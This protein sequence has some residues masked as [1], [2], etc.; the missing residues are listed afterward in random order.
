M[1]EASVNILLG[2]EAGQGLQTVGP[3]LAKSLVRKGYS[4][5]VTQTYESRVRGGHNVFAIRAGTGKILSPCDNIDIL[6]CLNE[7][8]FQINRDYLTTDALVICVE[9][10]KIDYERQIV[11]PSNLPGEKVTRN[12]AAIGIVAGLIGVDKNSL[13]QVFKDSL[14]NRKANEN[15]DIIEAVYL[16][17]D[18]KKID[19]KP[20]PKII[21]PEKKWLL[22]GHEAV[23]FG[24]I[25]AGI[26]FCSFYPMSP[27]TSI[28]QTLIDYS[29]RM[30]LIVEQVED[31]I[32]AINM[33][34]GASYAGAPAIVPTSGGGFALMTEGVSLA[35]IS[36]TP[37]VIIIAQRPGP[38]TGLATRTEQADLWLALHSGHGEF[39][40]VIYAPGNVEECFH[41]T[42]NAAFAA[43]KY[44]VPAFVLTD[45]YIAESYQDVQ[46][47]DMEKLAIIKPAVN[48]SNFSPIYERYR[49]TQ[50]GISPRLLPGF[51]EDLVV[52][53]SHE[54]TEAGH[55]TEDL[56][57]RPRMVDKRLIKGIYLKD[58]AVPPEYTGNS[59]PDILFICWGSTMGAVKEA[60]EILQSKGKNTSV[61]HF[62]QVWPLY[63][64]GFMKYIEKAGRVI[65]IEGNATGQF[66]KLIRRET[67]FLIADMVLR[68]DGLAI[69]PDYILERLEI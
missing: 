40:R 11:I 12:S 15:I 3:I 47:V 14:D 58:E 8:S 34:L 52:A 13:I 36:E 17:L 51:S 28:A 38:G 26:K 29:G 59:E 27:A 21:R 31:E 65:S 63:P 18:E 9:D 48:L 69:T 43:E 68:Y 7:E 39:P 32:A 45:Q 56:I 20:L 1:N 6:V 16:W 4:V 23:A 44:Q 2:G 33:A 49:I 37:I 61:L 25:S 30:G 66:A 62:S 53:D 22:T 64:D 5:H 60:S 24:A 54:H 55:M 10:W 41:L 42:R 67:G 46:P 19:F 35:G 50:N 57:L